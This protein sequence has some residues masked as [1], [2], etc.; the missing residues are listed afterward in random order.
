MRRV[1]AVF[2]GL[3]VGSIVNSGLI[4][5]SSHVI[6]PPAGA[7]MTTPEGIRHALPLLRPEHFLFPFLA[8]ALGTLVGAA[9]AGVVAR[10]RG[11]SAA[12]IIG[13]VFF[14]GGIAAAF[15]IPAPPWFIAVDLLFAYLPAAHLGGNLAARLAPA[16]AG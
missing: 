8:H 9:V 15:M 13:V 6:P 5:V 11:A 1:L 14:L 3:L 7:D 12:R 4:M 10:P 16:P 2:L